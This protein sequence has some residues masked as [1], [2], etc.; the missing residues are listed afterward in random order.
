M[1]M[2][3][4]ILKGIYKRTEILFLNREEAQLVLKTTSRNI[5]TLLAGM[6]KLGAKTVVIT[7]GRDGSYASNGS[8]KVWY[9]D[10]FEGQH[11]EATGA[12]D[13]YG[14]AF[15]AAIFYGK[16]LAEAITWGTINGGNV[17]MH[18]GPHAGLQTKQQIEN[19]M[20]KHPKFKAKEI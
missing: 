13:A 8:G 11:V 9:L 19:Y 4:H 15:T 7:D 3:T 10:Q 16:S 14:T 20:K 6:H 5:K 17:A 12:G 1:R 2:G 18:I